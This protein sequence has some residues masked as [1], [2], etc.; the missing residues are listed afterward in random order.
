MSKERMITIA[1]VIFAFSAIAFT[2]INLL[3]FDY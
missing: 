1:V 3:T 2:F